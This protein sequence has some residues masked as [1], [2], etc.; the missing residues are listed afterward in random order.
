MCLKGEDVMC[1]DT[2]QTP[3]RPPDP[4][5]RLRVGPWPPH[6]LHPPPSLHLL[7]AMWTRRAVNVE[8]QKAVCYAQKL[9]VN[10]LK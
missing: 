5:S 7:R 1:Q 10:S 3:E 2:W 9:I 8:Q 6:P 4:K